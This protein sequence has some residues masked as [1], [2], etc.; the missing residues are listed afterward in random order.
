M[1]V[2][3]CNVA[4]A[5]STWL[6]NGHVRGEFCATTR[7]RTHGQ[8]HLHHVLSGVNARQRC[9]S[10][11]RSCT[12]RQ[13]SSGPD[14]RPVPRRR[15]HGQECSPSRLTRPRPQDT[16]ERA[17][18][19]ISSELLLCDA[20]GDGYAVILAIEVVG[21]AFARAQRRMESLRDSR[22]SDDGQRQSNCRRLLAEAQI[23]RDYDNDQILM[24]ELYGESART[25]SRAWPRGQAEAERCGA[26]RTASTSAVVLKGRGG[27]IDSESSRARTRHAS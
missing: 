15:R 20:L 17:C 11:S 7:S 3:H 25:S 5:S 27:Q 12:D 26:G 10:T 16:T 1:D 9:T 22:C 24:A 14:P 18:N 6:E 2:S 4:R 13:A 21:L 23:G 19:G 8:R